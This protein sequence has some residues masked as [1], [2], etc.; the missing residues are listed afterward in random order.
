[1]QRGYTCFKTNLCYTFSCM[2]NKPIRTRFAPSP[3][4]YLHLGGLRTAL[5]NYLFAKKNGGVCFFRL[6]DTDQSRLVEDAMHNLLN[7]LSWCGLNFDES[8]DKPGEF[9]PYIQS[10]RLEIY[11]KYADQLLSEGKAYRCFCSSER[12]DQLRKLQQKNHQ[13]TKYDR[14]CLSLT[15]EE[16]AS[17]LD[18]GEPYTIRFKIPDDRMIEVDDMIRGKVVFNSNEIDD[19][20][21]M[22]SDGFPTYHLAHAVDDHLM[23]TTHVIRGEEWLPST[24]KHVLLFEALG[25]PVPIYAH[26]PLMLNPDRSKL[27]K[28]QGDVAVEDYKEKGYLPTAIVNFVAMCGW[29]PGEGSEEEVFTLE[30]LIKE[31]D[32]EK[33]Q[34]AGAVCDLTKAKWY[35]KEYLK[36]LPQEELAKLIRKTLPATWPQE[37]DADL[38]KK[39]KT[40][41][42]RID[43]ISEAPEALKF[44][45]EWQ[46]PT[47]ELL[48]H[49]KFVPTPEEAKIS[50]EKY[51]GFLREIEDWTEKNL[52]EKTIEWIKANE[53]KT[54]AILWPYR[55][56]I[57][58]QEHSPGPFEVSAA[59][60]KA[61]SIRRTEE[62]LKN[63]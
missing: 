44:Y 50:L 51:V 29:H 18:A 15:E 58:G 36:K 23:Q 43:L 17:K 3:T 60:G 32:L 22:K 38:I 30:E 62:V 33:V 56:A 7:T 61:E 19:Q 41:Q 37:E 20:V 48:C 25:F 59:L 12:L 1:M 6:E 16:I 26:L 46:A 13:P 14:K 49:K 2:N 34:K 57:T 10:Q 54:G 35:N 42:E 52:E 4:G 21:L 28:R 24:P 11:K 27:S 5:Y 39:V 63:I 40:V 53:Y 31:F 9:G 8:P 45:Y 55:V 47:A